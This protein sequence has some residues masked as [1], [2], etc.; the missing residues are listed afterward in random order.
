MQ[1]SKGKRKQNLSSLK[2]AYGR[3]DIEKLEIIEEMIGYVEDN[4]PNEQNFVP[5]KLTLRHIFQN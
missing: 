2:E 1:K 4:F 3:K 5:R